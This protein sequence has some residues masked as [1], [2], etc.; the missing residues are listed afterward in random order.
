MP[1]GGLGSSL[2][3]V[4]H[5]LI[6]LRR[7]HDP[8][9]EGLGPSVLDR[10]RE[11]MDHHRVLDRD[12]I[13]N[14]ARET[15]APE[16]IVYGVATYYGDLSLA[17]RGDTRLHVCVGTACVATAGEEHVGWLR[18]A[19]GL[20]L[21]QTSEDRKTSLEPAYCL[22]LCHAAPAMLVDRHTDDGLLVRRALGHLTRDRAH[23]I[24][25]GDLELLA[26]PE[27]RP[28]IETRGTEA[29]VLRNM[30]D[31]ADASTLESAR[32]RGV[33]R[34]YET[35]KCTKQPADVLEEIVTSVLRGR[36][37]A[38]FATGQKWRF[39]AAQSAVE[40]WVVCNADE[41]DPGSY[42]DK[43]LL[44]LDPHGVLEG[45]ALA[46]FAIGATR[47]AIYIRSEYPRAIDVMKRAVDEAR[48]AGFL[49]T[50]DVAVVEGA[51]SYVCGE[52]TALL[53]SIEGLRGMVTARPPYPA[54]KGLFEQP[55]VVNNVETLLNVPWIVEHGGAAYAAIGVGKSRGTKAISL[56]ERFARPGL[57]EVPL[58]ISLRVICEEIGG[59]LASGKPIKGVQ[60]GGPLGGI[61]PAS[62]FD[63][64]FGFEEL[65]AIGG[66]LGHGGLVAFEEGTD[67]RG[68]ARHLFEFGDAESCG[69]CFPCR[70]G[71][72]R[73]LELV[74]SMIAEGGKPGQLELLG[75]L[76]ETMQYG[77]L[78]AH[79]GGLPAA[80][81]SIM[82]HWRDELLAGPGA[83]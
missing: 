5:N 14:I 3:R 81:D 55:T 26:E 65:D 51:G 34:V 73:G 11:A 8:K 63:T 60:I 76:L 10:L 42:I 67:M 80:I 53:R 25:R 57:Y 70:L 72:R 12:A 48:R 4:S 49:A 31:G 59:G 45:M 82:K 38:G 33:W 1:A 58:G 18:E 41:G 13:A 79:G 75:E 66:L 9:P 52:E 74:D 20:A 43:W 16:A 44:E 6:T 78:C 22:G 77:S 29:I 21:G 7:K 62:L 36:G 28:P 35:T 83:R 56:N 50:F 23:A 32:A 54:E 40:K 61:I 71:M 68:I 69:K 47:G 24:A 27:P 46:G 39:A 15:G 37:G 19:T 30:I 2:H 17:R 64:P